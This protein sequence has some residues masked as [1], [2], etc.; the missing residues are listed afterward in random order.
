MEKLGRNAL[1]H[2]GSGKKYKRCHLATDRQNLTMAFDNGIVATV[3]SVSASL[4]TTRS[5]RVPEW[6]LWLARDA[7]HKA[8]EPGASEQRGLTA[9]LLIAAAGEAVLN[10]LLES[11]VSTEEFFGTGE[12]N[13]LQ[14]ASMTKKWIR[15][16]Q[17]LHIKPHFHADAPPLKP[18]LDT[19]DVRNDVMHFKHGRN[20]RHTRGA[21]IE[22]LKRDGKIVIPVHEVMASPQQTVS[23]EIVEDKIDPS[24]A[25]GYLTTLT[26]V[27]QVVLPVYPNREIAEVI[28]KALTGE[29]WFTPKRPAALWDALTRAQVFAEKAL[30]G[31]QPPTTPTQEVAAGALLRIPELLRSIRLLVDNGQPLEAYLLVRA[32]AEMAVTTAWTA[33]KDEHAIAF[34]DEMV[35]QTEAWLD[36]LKRHEVTLPEEDEQ[37]LRRLFAERTT[38][39]MPALEQR[40]MTMPT[41]LQSVYDFTHRLGMITTQ[42]E[43]RLAKVLLD[44]KARPRGEDTLVF[45]AAATSFLME[46]IGQVLSLE[47][48]QELSESLEAAVSP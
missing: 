3:E 10:W 48:T 17:L 9:V 20:V 26:N 38:T 2:C 28:Q 6:L 12:K 46:S 4:V 40:A 35:T 45:A 8:Q 5:S 21:E 42:N 25:A 15:L 34:R 37:Q 24:R 47:G 44:G 31:L 11:L 43:W 19:I 1:C 27:L 39:R 30:A 33:L 29:M 32:L 16:S 7:V 41:L 18:L 36:I 14:F 22:G 13:S 23:G